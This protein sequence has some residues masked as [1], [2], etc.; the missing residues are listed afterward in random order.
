ML[1]EDDDLRA[2]YR[3]GAMEPLEQGIRGRAT[4]AALGGEQL[5]HHRLAGAAHTEFVASA[6]SSQNADGETCQDER[7][8]HDLRIQPEPVIIPEVF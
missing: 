5:H 6:R 7:T 1:A 3:L 4:G 2:G 8:H